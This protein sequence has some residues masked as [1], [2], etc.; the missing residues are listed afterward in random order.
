MNHVSGQGAGLKRDS[1]GVLLDWKCASS[2]LGSMGLTYLI[3]SVILLNGRVLAD[4][5]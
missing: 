4:G 3:L 2:E 1:D 5:T